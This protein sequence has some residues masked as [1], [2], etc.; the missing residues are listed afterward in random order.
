M[1]GGTS[2][3]TIASYTMGRSARESLLPRPRHFVWIFDPYPFESKH[4][5]PAS[6]GNVGDVLLARHGD[7]ALVLGAPP[8]HVVHDGDDVRE[9]LARAR[10][11]GEYVVVPGAGGAD[12]LG[13]M[14][15]ELEGD[16]WVVTIFASP[17]YAGAFVVEDTFSDQIVDP[18]P[19]LEGR[20]E[21]YEGVWPQEAVFDALSDLFF[22]A[23]VFD[24]DETSCA[25]PV[26]FDESVA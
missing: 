4:L 15:V 25:R 17:E 10:A 13:L 16:S 23:G 18:F 9:A 21:L 1:C 19:R 22:D 24:P 2:A 14:A 26:V 12:G 7:V 5:R 11:G 3:S 6:V 20:V 8:K